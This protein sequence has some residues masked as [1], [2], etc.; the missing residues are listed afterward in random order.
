MQRRGVVLSAVIG[1]F[2]LGFLIYGS[3]L[4]NEFVYL[5]DNT[6]IFENPAISDTSF[7]SYKWIAT[8]YDPELY[9][10]LTFLSYKM[11]YLV[12]GLNPFVFHLHN[13]V[14]HVLNALLV[15]VFVGRMIAGQGPTFAPASPVTSV[16][17]PGPNEKKRSWFVALGVGLLFL[18]H[19]LHTEAVAWASARK[20]LL[21][22]L[23]FL[24]SLLAYLSYVNGESRGNRPSTVLRMTPAAYLF[25]VFCFLL[26]LLSKVSIALLPLVLILIDLRSGQKVDR[27]M[28]LSKVP[29]FLLSAIF[30]VVAMFGKQDVLADSTVLHTILMAGKST[31]FYL[32]KL[33]LPFDL[34]VIYPQQ[35]AISAASI[36]FWGAWFLLLVLGVLILWSLRYTK[37][38]LFW[39]LFSALALLPSF[40]NYAKAG[41]L[42]F[43]SDRYAYI[44]SVGLLVLVC[45]MLARLW[46]RA[47]RA[48][49]LLGIGIIV[50]LSILSHRQSRVWQSTETLM[51]NTLSLY[52]YSHLA[53][54]KVGIMQWETGDT[55]RALV[56]LQRSLEIKDN[57]SA[58]YNLGLIAL[59]E[60]RLNHAEIEFSRAVELQPRHV[61]S[62]VNLGYIA[63][64]NGQ[65]ERSIELFETALSIDARD[66]DALANL[67]SIYVALGRTEDARPLV[68]RLLRINGQ[69][70]IASALAQKL[71][72]L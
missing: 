28:L 12:G 40:S 60:G 38:V 59:S 54:N 6:L 5:D 16:G 58:H 32:Y 63:W 17:K 21:S 65:Q 53:H 27:K 11:D 56:H 18:V 45:M 22:T 49:P 64:E 57:P 13:L 9:I 47:R 48:V 68:E 36:D 70:P 2:A 69:D 43:A 15:M 10:P 52:D 14:L 29:F 62:Y 44:P 23:F 55:Q 46:G 72:I 35:E 42:F 3:S 34:S 51:L 67:A 61:W 33:I 50:C 20:D 1:F 4:S 39:G 71:G 41:D 7:H 26:A 30:I 31:V 19:P 37:E 66:T 24:L 25:S 8:H